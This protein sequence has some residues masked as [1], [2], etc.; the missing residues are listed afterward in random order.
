M[1]SG[2]RPVYVQWLDKDVAYIITPLERQAFL[3]LKIDEERNQFIAS[4]W[5]RRDPVPDTIENEFRDEHY[6]RIAHANGNFAFGATAGWRTDRGRIFI[7]YGKPD[8]VG[9]T[10]SGEVWSYRHIVGVG[11]DVKFEFVDATGTGDFRLLE[12]N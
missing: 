9:K 6:A 7:L 5:Q 3:Q 2:D 10:S 4:F 8:A 1:R 11:A 12:K